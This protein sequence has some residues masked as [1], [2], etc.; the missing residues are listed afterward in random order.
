[1]LNICSGN[2]EEDIINILDDEI[3]GFEDLKESNDVFDV[4]TAWIYLVGLKYARD[5]IKN[6]IEMHKEYNEIREEIYKETGL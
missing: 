3:S 6:Y 1:M 2:F 4:F 5:L